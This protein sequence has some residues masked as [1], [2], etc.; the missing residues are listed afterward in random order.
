MPRK[1]AELDAY[2]KSHPESSMHGNGAAVYCSCQCE[3]CKRLRKKNRERIDRERH[4]KER[5][6]LELSRAEG[7]ERLM[8]SAKPCRVWIHGVGWVDLK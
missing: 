7:M 4:R 2:L 6:A 8:E 1:Y 3:K 5:K